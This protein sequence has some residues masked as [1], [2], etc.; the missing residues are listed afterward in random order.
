MLNYTTRN[1]SSLFLI[2][3]LVCNPAWVVFPANWFPTNWF[4]TQ[5]QI[6]F[7]INGLVCKPAW[8]V[9]YSNSLKGADSTTEQYQEFLFLRWQWKRIQRK[10]H[11]KD[12]TMPMNARTWIQYMLESNCSMNLSWVPAQRLMTAFWRPQ[13]TRSSTTYFS[14]VASFWNKFSTVATQDIISMHMG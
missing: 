9:F 4:P 7:L 5:Q 12:F 2:I 1:T 10:I 14:S 11:N 8:I 3:V 6:S 13:G